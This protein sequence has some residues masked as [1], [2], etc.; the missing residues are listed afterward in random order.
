MENERKVVR[1]LRSDSADKRQKH[2]ECPTGKLKVKLCGADRKSC[3]HSETS[4]KES[5]FGK[6]Q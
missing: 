4:N 3:R 5:E 6:E 2:V 1:K